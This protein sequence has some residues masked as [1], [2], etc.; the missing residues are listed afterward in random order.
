MLGFNGTRFLMITKLDELDT[1]FVVSEEM[2]FNLAFGLTAYDG[3]PKF[4]EDEDYATLTLKEIA[5]GLEDQVDPIDW[6]VVPTRRCNET[7][8]NYGPESTESTFF[9]VSKSNEYDLRKYGA[10]MKCLDKD[11]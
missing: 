10:K 7:D 8:F 2:G 4:I 3:S 6:D 9:P 5:W 1:D 11:D